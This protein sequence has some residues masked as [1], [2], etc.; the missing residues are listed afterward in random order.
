MIGDFLKLQLNFCVVFAL[1]LTGLTVKQFQFSVAL[2]IVLD[3]THLRYD[4]R[5]SFKK[6]I[7]KP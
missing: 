5:D 3:L 7:P 2:T 6:A 4:V 1:R